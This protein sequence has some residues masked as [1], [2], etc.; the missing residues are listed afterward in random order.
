M[1][2]ENALSD[3]IYSAVKAFALKG[4]LL[5]ISTLETLSESKNLEDLAARLKGTLYSGAISKLSKPYYAAKFELAFREHLV[6]LHHA[7]GA[8]AQ[9]PDLIWAYYLKYIS[10]NLKTVLKGRA[11]G[12]SFEDMSSHL[13][14]YA[15][16]LV[17]RRDIVVRALSA[18][19]LDDAVGFVRG[20][21][22][23]IEASGALRVFKERGNVQVFDIYLEKAFLRNLSNVYSQVKRNQRFAYEVNKIE[24]L[25]ALDIDS[26][27]LLAVLRGK[28]WDLAASEIRALIVD[29]TFE[30]GRRKLEVMI[31][32]PSVQDAIKQI[33]LTAYRTAMPAAG[34]DNEM[35]NALEDSLRLMSYE[36][37][38]HP[39][40][41]DVFGIGVVLG[42]IRLKELEVRNLSGIAVGIEKGSTVPEISS[43]IVRLR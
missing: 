14:L 25:M 30:V 12:K 3:P 33:A 27:N 26:Y 2:K 20:T 4:T 40:I 39:F 36:R 41:W 37:A 18:P 10:S 1:N 42:L 8:V 32:A 6:T 43:K 28:L 19:T 31:A 29:P 35:I 17:G 11:L 34:S 24:P 5:P 22:F 9:Y 16:E 13:D 23:G 21:E 38:Y 7:I 15:E